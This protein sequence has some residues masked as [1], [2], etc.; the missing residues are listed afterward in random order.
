MTNFTTQVHLLYL[1]EVRAFAP[2]GKEEKKPVEV[3]SANNKINFFL[4]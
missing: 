3:R 4:R 1:P 2:R